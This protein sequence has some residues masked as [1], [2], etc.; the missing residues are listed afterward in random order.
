MAE[1]ALSQL[2]LRHR[3]RLVSNL[4]F[5]S[6]GKTTK[7]DSSRAAEKQYLGDRNP[8]WRTSEEGRKRA[9]VLTLGY[10]QVVPMGLDWAGAAGLMARHSLACPTDSLIIFC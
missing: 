10:N 2:S 3:I 7:S 1:I 6:A 5:S 9:D 4:V 8:G